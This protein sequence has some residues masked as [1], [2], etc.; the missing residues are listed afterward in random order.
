[1]SLDKMDPNLLENS[2]QAI[3]QS[4]NQ[5]QNH[6]QKGFVEVS[7]E[8]RMLNEKWDRYEINRSAKKD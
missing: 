6:V 5:I 3:L 8:L 4:L 1:M 2:M 7:N